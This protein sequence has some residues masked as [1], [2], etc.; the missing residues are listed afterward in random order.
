MTA[1]LIRGRGIRRILVRSLPLVVL[2]IAATVVAFLIA[3]WGTKAGE[4]DLASPFFMGQMALLSLVNV[5]VFGV[6][7]MYNSLWEYASVDDA[8]RIV[9]ATA[10]GSVIGDVLGALVFDA[11]MP[12]RVY[13]CAWAILLVICGMARFAIRVNSKGRSWSFLGAKSPGQARTLIVGAGESGSLV[14]SRML[15]GSDEI[16]GCPVGYVDDSKRKIGRRIHGVKVL[17][18]CG[19]IPRICKQ[20][21]IEQ[22]V[23]AI[24]SGTQKQKRRVYD[25]CMETGCKVLT[26]PEKVKDIPEEQ[27]SKVPI[28]DVEVSDLLAREEVA[29]DE[30]LVGT[31]LRGTTVLVTG[32]GGSIGSELV[33][34]LLPAKPAKIILFDIYENTVYELYHEIAGKAREAGIEIVTE[35]GSITHMP[36]LEEV[37]DRHNPHVVFHAAAH[38]HVPLM[39]S[40]PREAI[41]NNVFGTLNVVRMAHER[42]CSHFILISTDKA[43]NPANVMGATKRMC[44]MVVQH[45]AQVSKTVFASVRFGNVLGSHGSVTPLFKRQLKA[46]GPITLTHQDITRYFMTIPEAA[47]LVI[48]AGAL[49]EGGEIFVLDMGEPVRIY[50]LA[51]N[52]IRLSGLTVGEDIEIKVTGLRP[53]EKLYEEL[54][55]DDEPT[56]PTANGA[57]TVIKGV[58]PEVADVRVRLDELGAALP[59]ERDEIKRVLQKAVP[60]YTPEFQ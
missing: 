32:G 60:T 36:A 9:F 30:G 19:G 53:G 47:R 18:D 25:L 5:A 26:L 22:I 42:G 49:A 59:L 57:I 4:I 37:F 31:Y 14:V 56:V 21:S 2:D 23:V 33:R 34:Q 44:E 43:V 35:I 11:R 58:R 38:K 13:I 20:Q 55:M 41:E 7:R 46:G 16:V 6:F 12:F 29:L 1:K 39:E 54:N 15:A 28:R 17:G 24:P 40:N 45:Y 27:L 48:T 50:D 3:A 8:A 51:E 10:V 52:L